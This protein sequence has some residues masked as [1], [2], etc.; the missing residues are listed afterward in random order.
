MVRYDLE[1][2]TAYLTLNR[3]EKRN[4][5][6]GEMVT[7][8]REALTRAEADA[9]A[10]VVVVRAEG[11]VFCA[12]ADLGALRQ[13]QTA[14]Y[15]DNLA[16]SEHLG[17]LF[18]Q[19]YL[20]P[21]PVVAQV[22]GHAIAGGCGLATVCDFTFAAEGARFGYTEVRIG[23]VPALVTVFLTR[24]VGEGHAK[25]LLM[26]GELITAARAREVGL[27]QEVLPPEALAD[28]V[29]TFA[30][31]LAEQTSG[32]SLAATKALLAEVPALPLD[33]ALQ[34]AAAENARARGTD[35]CRRGIAAFLAK[36]KLT[37]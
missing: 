19:I 35:D 5:L 12:G 16:D 3:P 4:A 36:E 6:N 37:W 2:R 24:K 21:K 8:L 30:D 27:I 33:D 26:T 32:E 23:F 31:Q 28:R 17:A 14:T 34:R 15:D 18:R 22:H 29:R 1:G 7:A 13:L 10:R 11:K 20:G 9:G 25:S